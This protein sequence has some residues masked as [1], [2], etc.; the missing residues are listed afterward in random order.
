MLVH[1][2]QVSDTPFVQI[3]SQSH[4]ADIILAKLSL[5]DKNF[6]ACT[7]YALNQIVSHCNRTSLVWLKVTDVPIIAREL[8]A[9]V[10][11]LLAPRYKNLSVL[12]KKNKS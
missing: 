3:L 1:R 12:R 2:D 8:A 6:L 9:N 4:L 5:A 7:S 10:R 11:A